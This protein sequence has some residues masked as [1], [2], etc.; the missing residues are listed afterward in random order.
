MRGGY[1]YD[2]VNG[3]W[4]RIKNKQESPVNPA[5]SS[6]VILEDSIARDNTEDRNGNGTLDPGEDSN[7]NG[8][9]D[10]GGVIIPQG[11]VAVFPL[12]TKVP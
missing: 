8:A 9:I 10:R 2:P 6:I 11:V 12:E 5:T 1:I 3:L 4:Y 7:G